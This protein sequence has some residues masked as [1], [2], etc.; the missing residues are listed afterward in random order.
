MDTADDAGGSEMTVTVGLPLIACLVGWYCVAWFIGKPEPASG[1]FAIPD[2]PRM[3]LHI[4]N[5]MAWVIVW[6]ICKV[7]AG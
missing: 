4:I 1:Y 5:S 7:V 2:F 6:L 3:F